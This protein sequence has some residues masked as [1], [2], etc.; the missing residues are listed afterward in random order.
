MRLG[1]VALGALILTRLTI[2]ITRAPNTFDSATVAPY[3]SP[4]KQADVLL[5]HQTP[6]AAGNEARRDEEENLESR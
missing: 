6:H 3:R 5:K 2:L 1:E 4:Q